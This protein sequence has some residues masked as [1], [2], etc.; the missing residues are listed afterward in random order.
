[1]K[2]PRARLLSLFLLPLCAASAK[3]TPPP[4]AADRPGAVPTM[5]AAAIGAARDRYERQKFGLF[6]HYV[7]GLTRDAQGNKPNIDVLAR[8]LDA[9]QF[10]QDAADFGVEYV[11]FTVQHLK[12]RMLYPSAVNKRWRDDRRAA[13]AEGAVPEGKSY[14]DIDVIDRLATELAKRNIDLHLYAHPV[15]GHDFSPEDQESTGWNDCDRTHGDHARWNQFQNELFD[16]LVHRY[17]GRIKGLWFDG[18]FQHSGKKPTHDLIDQP[19]FRQ[20]L[21]S[22]DPGLVLVANVA[23]DRREHPFPEWVAADYR[24]WEVS[25]VING[26]LGFVSI[27]REA[28]DRKPLTWPAT[29]NQLAM[30]VARNWWAVSKTSLVRQTPEQLLGYLVHQASR[31]TH[32]GFAVS[33]GPFPGSAAQ[34]ENGNIWE[35]DFHPTMVRLG[36]LIAPIGVAIRD[37][38]P[39]RAYVTK[40]RESL[41][42]RAWGVSTESPDGR[43]VY[44]HVLRP[45]EGRVLALGPTEDGSEFDTDSARL[46]VSGK[47]VG[48]RKLNSC[49]ELTLPE[50]VAWDQINTVVSVRRR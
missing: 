7:P 4:V 25:R 41:G 29:R 48:L 44:L 37:T 28:H 38:R 35:G 40:E 46:L 10:A 2:A 31:S 5:D 49:Y 50:G 26:V 33:A 15:D 12:A 18:M 3:E 32:G 27:N 8:D 39:G 34:Q 16:E 14:S 30:V 6:V 9:A 47:P 24:A 42:Q 45:P 19:R 17:R 43:T 1:M 11:I 36:Q 20:T 22:Y 13:P 21:L 23:G